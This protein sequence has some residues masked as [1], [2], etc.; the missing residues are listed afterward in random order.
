MGRLTFF[1]KN[2]RGFGV[3]QLMIVMSISMVT[4]LAMLSLSNQLLKSGAEQADFSELDALAKG[5]VVFVA[6]QTNWQNIKNA[7]GL[8]ACFQTGPCTGVYNLANFAVY[9]FAGALMAGVE[10]PLIVD[11]GLP[12]NTPEGERGI[13]IN[14]NNGNWGYT[15]HGKFCTTF[16]QAP[17]NACPAR[18]KVNWYS[19]SNSSYPIVAVT[20]RLVFNQNYSGPRF[21]TGRFAFDSGPDRPGPI[22]YRSS[23]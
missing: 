17:Y 15:L 21:S 14:H 22:V 1:A 20:I 3:L 10:Q 13:H 18:F 6:D 8:T 11:D 7:N 9:D 5:I 2:Q 4:C 19:T 23:Y 16:N 12:T